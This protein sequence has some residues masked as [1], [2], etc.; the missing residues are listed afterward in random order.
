MKS[1][2]SYEIEILKNLGVNVD[3]EWNGG[4]IIKEPSK[5][6]IFIVRDQYKR[7]FE[8][9]KRNFDLLILDEIVATLHF[10]LLKEDDILELMSKKLQEL[11][12]VLTGRG[13]TQ[14]MI[15]KADL[16]T[17]MKKIKH[18]FDKGIQAREGIEY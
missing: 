9:Y 16:V 11:E 1:W 3:R 10:G 18:Y 13:A 2:K 6:Q 8:V 12:L 7:V 5:E 14:K 4:F 15:Q 17:E